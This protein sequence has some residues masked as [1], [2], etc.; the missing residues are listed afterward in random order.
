MSTNFQNMN[1]KD[2]TAYVQRAVN[3]AR[4]LQRRPWDYKCRW[5]LDDLMPTLVE[6]NTVLSAKTNQFLLD[7]L[8]GDTV[9]GGGQ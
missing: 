3:K 4:R 5:A 6:A 2:L 9:Q 8:L 1:L 7:K